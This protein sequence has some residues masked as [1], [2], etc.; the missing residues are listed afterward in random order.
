MQSI[1][2]PYLYREKVAGDNL[3]P[4]SAK[5]FLLGRLPAPFWGWFDAMLFQNLGNP[6]CASRCPRLASAP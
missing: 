5:E 1:P 2:R 4:M 6:V 3:L